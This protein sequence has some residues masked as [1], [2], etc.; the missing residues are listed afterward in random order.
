MI[1]EKFLTEFKRMLRKYPKLQ[2]SD[3]VKHL[4]HGSRETAPELIY[5][6]EDG[7][8][9]RFSNSG[10]YGRGI[11]FADNSQYSS[12]YGHPVKKNGGGTF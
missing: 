8:D 9:F 6:S 4:F 7:L 11:Y 3:I 2:I 1:Y 5:G 10:M 12:T